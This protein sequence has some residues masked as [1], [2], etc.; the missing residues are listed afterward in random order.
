M[1]LRVNKGTWDFPTIPLKLSVQGSFLP[2]FLSLCSHLPIYLTESLSPSPLGPSSEPFS[3]ALFQGPSF[4]SSPKLPLFLSHFT[5]EL[6]F[7]SLLLSFCKAQSLP[8]PFPTHSFLLSPQPLPLLPLSYSRHPGFGPVP[9]CLL[10]LA[11]HSV[12]SG[13]GSGLLLP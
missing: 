2:F 12:V 5:S 10:L 7:K 8:L 1:K 3:M 13:I 11:E 4:Q 9:L 6:V